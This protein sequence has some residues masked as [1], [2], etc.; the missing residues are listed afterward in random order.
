MAFC[1]IGEVANNAKES[2]P[3]MNARYIQIVP[4]AILNNSNALKSF[5]IKSELK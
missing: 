2:D 1:H 5:L 4:N 3:I